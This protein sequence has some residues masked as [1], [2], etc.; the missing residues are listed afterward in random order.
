MSADWFLMIPLM[1][2]TRIKN[3]FSK[4]VKEELGMNE[5]SFS[6]VGIVGKDATFPF[7]YFQN[8]ASEESGNDLKGAD[9]NGVLYT[10]Q[11]DVTDNKS[12]ARTRK[13]MSEITLAMKKMRFEIVAMPS[14][15]STKDNTH[16][17]T[18]RFRRIIGANEKL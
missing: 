1:V 13:A 15:E 18:A 3:E 11:V 2:F 9:V 4:S 10:F 17:M 7:V 16:R 5:S 6:T 12:Q 8:I 14:F